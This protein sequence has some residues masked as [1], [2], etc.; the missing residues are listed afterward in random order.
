M[1]P[2]DAGGPSPEALRFPYGVAPSPGATVEVAPGVHWLRM[3]LP[4]ALDHINLYL[5]DEGA[6]GWTVVDTGIDTAATRAIWESQF[7]GTLDGRPVARV[8]VTH[9]H[10]DHIGLAGWLT[11]RWPDAPLW[12]SETEWLFAR[13]LRHALEDDGAR[14]TRRRFYGRMGLDAERAAS[15][16]E[17]P[18]AYP[19][20]V[21]PVP[22]SFRRIADGDTLSI[23]GRTWRV[24]VGRGH[25]PEHACLHCPELGLLL[26][27]DQVLPK[28]SPNVS[29]WPNEPEADPL[30]RFLDSL[31]RIRA[32]VPPDVL[33]LPSHNL[34]FAGL[35]TRLGQLAQHHRQRLDAIE[36]ACAAV[37][38][39]TAEIVPLLFHRALDTHQLGFATGEA[40]AHLHYLRGR[41]RLRAT[42]RADGVRLFAAT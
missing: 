17:R 23:G 2:P 11:E 38:R 6:D 37:P 16:I 35:H 40:L 5:I 39:S 29:V 9:F 18:S 12:I 36:E 22:Q 14:E 8:I 30:L 7:A 1:T 31:E 13:M 10:P 15:L 33:V 42:D 3:P 41:G 24:I 19:S 21:S 4:F 34:P 28:I 25:A 26:S 27:G 32:A 20:R